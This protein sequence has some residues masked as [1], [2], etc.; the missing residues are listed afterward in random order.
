VKELKNNNIKKMSKKL[1]PDQQQ[2]VDDTI[3]S[4]EKY[5][6]IILC[7]QTG[8][9]KTVMA[10]NLAHYF[11]KK[12]K[13]VLLISD[14]LELHGGFYNDLVE[15]GLFPF[16]IDADG[17]SLNISYDCYVAMSQTLKRRLNSST[18]LDW[19]RTVPD[20]IFLDECHKEEYNPYFEKGLFTGKKVIGLTATPKRFGSQRQLAEDYQKIVFGQ[21]T[22]SLI[23]L[24]RLAKPNYIYDPD[25]KFDTSK[26][27][28]RKK[29]GEYDFDEKEAGQLMRMSGVGGNAI[30]IYKERVHKDK[31]IAFCGGSA[32]TIEEC[33]AFN[34]AGIPSLYFIS[35]PQEEKAIVL[36]EK[37][38]S[39]YSGSRQ[40]VLNAHKTGAV[41]GLF[42]N[43]IFTTGYNDPTIK[44]AI[45]L[46]LT[47][48]P[49]LLSQMIGR[50]SRFIKGVKEEFW[51][52]DMSDNIRRMG[53]WHEPKKYS[54]HH[55]KKGGGQPVL[56]ECP[57]CKGYNFATVKICKLID[58]KSKEV[59][60][61]HYPEY[62]KISVP[63]NV[64]VEN[65]DDL[66]YK[67]FLQ[68]RSL[69]S[70]EQIN[71]YRETKKFKLEWMY[72]IAE[73]TGRMEEFKQTKFYNELITA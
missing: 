53:K 20:Y 73:Q 16:M 34:E 65:Y 62:D 50:A 54:L 38:K 31:F 35:E 19:L 29:L 56:K 1:F 23:A 49:N 15:E 59:C 7:S 58:P 13:V 4:L 43:N 24:E 39:K 22:Q 11:V 63:I 69:M 46:R 64:Q 26:L 60:N 3:E 5:N 30:K 33:V 61:F 44:G 51:V 41:L 8:S 21:E 66:L 12:G 18:Y 52:M 67:D 25:K 10:A 32:A 14:R 47:M 48:N 17:R 6:S 37:Y 71:R 55:T 9:G 68:K 40:Y 57:N 42:N 72:R 28:I 2:T 27:K 70:W 45:I 36:H